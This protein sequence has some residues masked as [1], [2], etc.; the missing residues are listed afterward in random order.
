VRLRLRRLEETFAVARLPARA[1]VPAWAE[2]SLTAVVRTAEELSIV[3][4]ADRVPGRVKHTAGWR[5][6]RLEGVFEFG[7]VGVLLSVLAPLARAR[8]GIFAFSTH[9]TDYVMIQE[10]DFPRALKALRSAGHRLSGP[11]RRARS[12]SR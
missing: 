11:L 10:R 12:A 3:C 2:G 1:R 7:L 9:D 4:R 5:C 8:V 6:L